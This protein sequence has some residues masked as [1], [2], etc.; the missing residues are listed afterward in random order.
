MGNVE[1]SELSNSFMPN[2]N[3]PTLSRND[4]FY[5]LCGLGKVH[6]VEKM[7]E[8]DK[9]LKTININWQNFKVLGKFNKF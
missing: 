9:T 1:G 5:Q 2:S 4:R 8:A 3:G 7:L 6:L